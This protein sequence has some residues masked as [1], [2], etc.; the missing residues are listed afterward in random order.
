VI[1]LNNMKI[2]WNV[3]RNDDVGIRGESSIYE[4]SC[5][6]RLAYSSLP[7]NL[8]MQDL[9]PTTLQ[10]QQVMNCSSCKIDHRC[11]YCASFPNDGTYGCYERGNATCGG[12]HA[13]HQFKASCCAVNCGE[14]H[15]LL[16]FISFK[17]GHCQVSKNYWYLHECRCN[18]WFYEGQGCESF[19]NSGIT[20]IVFGCFIPV[21]I[22][23]VAFALY[24]RRTLAD[25]QASH[26]EELENQEANT[27]AQLRERLLNNNDDGDDLRRV[28]V[29]K[30]EQVKQSFL[31]DLTEKLVLQDVLVSR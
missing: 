4:L 24:F 18:T 11:Q 22:L 21:F 6:G 14:H 31:Q 26:L 7:R 17:R 25:V 27:L 30:R 3:Q 2:S 29:D 16:G 5:S 8:E 15:K 12:K 20:I 9:F 13:P 28:G 1:S 23:F 19:S 10:H